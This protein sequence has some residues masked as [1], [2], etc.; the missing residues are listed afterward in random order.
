MRTVHDS[1]QYA[2]EDPHIHSY[3]PRPAMPLSHSNSSCP[4]PH[5]HPS[6]PHEAPPLH[7]HLAGS[8]SSMTRSNSNTSSNSSISGMAGHLIQP[9]PQTHTISYSNETEMDTSM[10]HSQPSQGGHGQGR[11]WK[12]TMGY[13]SDCEKCLQRVP[14]H[15]THVV[16]SS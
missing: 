8:P 7:Q 4:S 3:S 1:L 14:G 11:G 5:P 15:Y 9:F 13:R 2:S 16:Y 12:I 6:A 10:E